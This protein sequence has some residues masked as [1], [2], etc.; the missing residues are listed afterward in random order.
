[1]LL[2]FGGAKSFAEI[3]PD[4]VFT[5]STRKMDFYVKDGL[6]I[7]GDRAVDEVLIRDIRRSSSPKYERI[8]IDLQ[9]LRNGES[10]AIPRPPYFQVA[11]TPDEK[12]LLVSIWGRP[13]LGFDSANIS[14]QFKKSLTVRELQLLPRLEDQ[15]WT[16][17]I[18]LKAGRSVEVF[19]LTDPVRVI[20][21]VKRN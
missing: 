16:F 3:K 20:I 8:V 11:V 4:K 15:V 7:G 14:K 9:G 18:Q 10:L 12:R 19:E 2:I 21:D 1:M 17:A 6:V 5:A 13:K